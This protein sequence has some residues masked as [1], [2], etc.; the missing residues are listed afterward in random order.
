MDHTQQRKDYKV[1]WN[2]N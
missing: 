2:R 1:W